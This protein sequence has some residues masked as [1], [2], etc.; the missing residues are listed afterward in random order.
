MHDKRF[1]VIRCVI[2]RRTIFR[3]KEPNSVPFRFAHKGRFHSIV[4]DWATFTVRF[5]LRENDLGAVP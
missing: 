3:T 2:C 4:V 1:P 5:A